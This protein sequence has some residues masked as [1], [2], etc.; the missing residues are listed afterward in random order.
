V[1]HLKEIVLSECHFL[2]GNFGTGI[3]LNKRPFIT[4]TLLNIWFFRFWHWDSSVFVKIGTGIILN[5]AY[6]VIKF[7]LSG[8][9]SLHNISAIDK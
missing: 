2:R 8:F 4:E 3:V 7:E 1:I 6:L 9:E 5:K